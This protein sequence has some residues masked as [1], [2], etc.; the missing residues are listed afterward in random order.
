MATAI[1]ERLFHHTVVITIRDDSYRLRERRRSA[2]QKAG[3]M[4]ETNETTNR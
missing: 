1:L 3:P 2:F 4:P